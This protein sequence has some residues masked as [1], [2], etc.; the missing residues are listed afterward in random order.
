M[1]RTAFVTGASGFVGGQLVRTLILRGWSVRALGRAGSRL[2]ACA[3]LGADVVRADLTEELDPALLA[4]ADVAFHAAGVVGDRVTRAAA[5][6]VNVEG[7]R[8]VVEAALGAGVRRLVHTSSVAVYGFDAGAFDEGAPRRRVGEPYIDSKTAAEEICE[9][10]AASERLEVRILRPAVIYGPGDSG[11]LARMTELLASGKLPM[12]GDGAGHVGLVHVSDV[13]AALAAA[14]DHDGPERVFNVMGPDD[15]TWKNLIERI[16]EHFGFATPK[17]V[18]RAVAAGMG[19]VL[20]ALYAVRLA[21]DPLPLSSHAVKFLTAER[22]Y[23]TGRLR[24]QLGIAPAV[25]VEQGLARLWDTVRAS[26]SPSV[27]TAR[28]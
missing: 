23:P 18:P 8:H 28:A 9:S 24:E 20:S 13:V 21:P 17:R 25:P 19:A 12:I 3:R 4:G 15:L 22:S 6:A 10:G 7:T 2:D 1:Q 27:E 14:A 16:V 5:R 11:M 26:S